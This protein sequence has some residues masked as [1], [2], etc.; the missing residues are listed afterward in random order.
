MEM[1]SAALVEYLQ[2]HT[3]PE[4]E[5]LKNLDRETHLK[6]LQPRMLSGHYQG[7]LLAM[8]SYMLRPQYILE[9]GTYT[10]YSALCLAEGLAKDGKLY[11]LEVNEELESIIR[12]YISLAGFNQQIELLIGNAANLI[13]NLNLTFDLVFID[14]DKLNNA[15][16]YDL[17]VEK[18][19]ANGI[20][21]VDN[22]LWDGKILANHSDKK[23]LAIQAF[24]QKVQNDPRVES[25][26]LPIRDGLY[27]IRK[28]A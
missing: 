2:Q 10:G 8:I 21:L 17:V 11:T 14:A 23:T 19:R 27:M 1:F 7:R 25:L 26:I 15:H 24:N 9:I 4:S 20:I 13:P 28:K 18:V 22:V 12:K 16:Y 3:S 5:I 6:V